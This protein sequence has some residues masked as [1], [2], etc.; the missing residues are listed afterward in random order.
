MR[1]R[2]RDAYGER[3]ASRALTAESARRSS[4]P[5]LLWGLVFGG[6]TASAST[7]YVKSFPTRA[8]RQVFAA[9]TK[10]NAGFAALFG[11]L[12]RV[13]TVAG[14][15][16][17]KVGY[18]II[19]IG[20]I[21]GLFIATKLLRGEEES[22][23]W[24]LF[25]AGATTRRRAL[26]QTSMGLLAG[27]AVVWTTMAIIAVPAGSSSDVHI[28]SSASVFFVT[29]MISVVLM[30]MAVGTMTSQL[31]A[32]RHDANLYGGAVIAGA[33]VIRM[34]ADSD[35]SLSWLRWASPFGWIENMHVLTGSNAWPFLPVVAFL[36]AVGGSSYVIAS[37]RDAGASVFAGRDTA[38]PHTFLLGGQVGLNVRLTRGGVIAWTTILAAVGAV[39][40]LVTV[41]AGK[42][43]KTS[44][45]ISRAF[46][47]LGA[48][49]QGAV[50]Y[51]G[52]VFLIVAVLIAV[53]VASQI[54]AI[55]N[56]ES[57]G[58]LEN[59]LVRPVRRSSW[60]V[61]RVAIAI[62]LIALA[63]VLAGIAAWAGAASQHA[64]IGFVE[65]LKAGIN[66]TPPAVAILGAGVL[67]FALAPR[68]AVFVVYGLIVWSFVVDIVAALFN[69]NHWLRDTSPISHITPAPAASPNWTS[70]LV[71]VAIGIAACAVGVYAFGRRD[72]S[73]A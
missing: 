31:A 11:P 62:V 23:R 26:A 3:R 19:V 55:R 33:Y 47:R 65:L 53:A 67:T 6:L 42:L 72:L 1:I 46:G 40:G 34:V 68:A 36:C 25:L 13:D 7:T 12:R 10:G 32:T 49:R 56:E 5:A 71:L 30:F 61:S 14:Y 16:A 73:S 27:A 66:V 21:W 28:A 9:A 50:I 44:P 35:A 59:L 38:S 18:T 70:A 57:S 63:G 15:T 43:L 24:E 45:A 8:S 37:A 20:A 54:S 52:A 58:H 48:A 69:S 39:F 64:G 17:Y 4:R 29:A 22:G 2:K 60:L 51:L 41:S